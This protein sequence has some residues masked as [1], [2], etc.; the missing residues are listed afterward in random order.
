MDEE[1]TLT[2]GSI[3]IIFENRNRARMVFPSLDVKAKEILKTLEL[4]QPEALILIAGT[5]GKIEEDLN[6]RL[7]QLFSRGI[8]QAAVKKDALILDCGI[9]GGVMELM[10]QGVADRKR[11]ATLLGVAPKGMV[12]YPGGPDPDRSE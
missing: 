1:G 10:G 6:L 5:R 7:Q 8:A 4:K 2:E 12:T 9:G 3:E 11:A